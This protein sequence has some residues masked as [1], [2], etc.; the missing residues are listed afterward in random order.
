VALVFDRS[1]TNERK[2]AVA[3][4]I[5]PPRDHLDL[6]LIV[7]IPVIFILVSLAVGLLA[8]TLT[9]VSLQSPAANSKNLL[10]LHAWI[11]GSSLL[12]GLLGA[13]LAYGIAKPVR[14]AFHEAR[15]MIQ[16]AQADPDP[17]KAA[18]EVGALST[19]FEQ[20]FVSFVELVQAREMLDS[21]NEGIVAIDKEG[22]VA[23]INSRAQELLE[24][25]FAEARHKTF[26]DLLGSTSASGVL[27]GMIQSVLDDGEERVHNHVPFHSPSG[28]EILLSVKV[29]PLTLKTEPQGLLGAVVLLKEQAS[30]FPELHDIVGQTEQL[31]DLLNL[32][33][34]VAPT[35][36]TVLLIGE[37]GTGKELIANALHR[38]SRR[39]DKPFVKL[40]CAAI[41]EGLLESELF[42]HEKGAFTGAVGRKAGKFELADE[43]TIFLDEIADMPPPTQAK[44]LRVLQQREFTL[45]GGSEPKQADVR[46]VVA[47]NRDLFEEVLKG[48]FREDL[49][50]R[51]NVVTM[52]LPPLRERKAD[53]PFLAD[54]FLQKAAQK[55]ASPRKSL[56]RSALDR[57]MAHSWPGNIRELENALERASL[58][59]RGTVIEPEDLSFLAPK[60]PTEQAEPNGANKDMTEKG[61]SLNETLESVEKG[62]IIEALRKSQGVQV[63]AAKLLGL[64]H[65]NLWHKIR[66]HKIDLAHLRQNH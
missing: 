22:K 27:L 30:K 5:K 19:V 38:L 61:V 1:Q 10:L 16:Y 54:H 25:S 59:S 46:I 47:S 36:A 33:V 2:E 48:K 50:Y 24:T 62:L 17:I 32:V 41:P 4:P 49:F 42:G 11:V 40:N 39:K 52:S 58:F 13:Y 15:K 53:I 66:K 63:E 18:D 55:T 20:A 44:V 6:R 45:V 56:S 14:K 9:R 3:S 34:K 23:G 8:T 7:F 26:R 60:H 12:A 43:G 57:L 64:N 65:K 35:D 28:K 21:V 51:L 29:S 37:S 31:T